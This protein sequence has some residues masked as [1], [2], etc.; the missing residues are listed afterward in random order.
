[1]EFLNQLLGFTENNTVRAILVLA[2]VILL[3][4][5][6]GYFMRRITR[7]GAGHKR[8]RVARLSIIEAIAID[9]RRRLVLV[10]RDNTEHLLMIGGASDILIEEKIQRVARPAG[11]PRQLGERIDPRTA[12]R[13]RATAEATPIGAPP[14]R[15]APSVASGLSATIPTATPAAPTATVA[16]PQ[17]PV[18]APSSGPKPVPVPVPPPPPP[19]PVSKPMVPA[20]MARASAPIPVTP[21]K[22]F[23]QTM[24]EAEMK[25]GAPSAAAASSVTSETTQNPAATAPVSKLSPV[26][27][28]QAP[29]K[30]EPSI[31]KPSASE[32]AASSSSESPSLNPEAAP[33]EPTGKEQ[34]LAE[35]ER[36]LE[37]A[38]RGS[39]AENPASE[40]LENTVSSPDKSEASPEIDDGRQ[41]QNTDES[42]NSNEAE[43]E[44]KDLQ[45]D[46]TEKTGS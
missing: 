17:P 6:L 5:V 7:R 38:L 43:S 2:A 12:V 15:A 1:M 27:P 11:V 10:R 13:Q 26:R 14:Q 31:S 29:F 16:Q 30:P 40:S 42:V 23:P 36:Q 21:M 22:A 45:P 18:S 28:S 20:S 3:I 34:Q 39:V 44:T 33:A 25:V 8:G 19:P 24:T 37:N 41:T 32:S 46:N 9:Q 35:M 4:I